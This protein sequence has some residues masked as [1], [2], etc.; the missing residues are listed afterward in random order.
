VNAPGPGSRTVALP[1]YPPKRAARRRTLHTG[2][3][4]F[5]WAGAAL[6]AAS[7]SY[8]LYTYAFTF[9]ES[10][11]GDV[12]LADA[13]ADVALFT[14]FA[15]HHSLFAREGVRAWVSRTLSPAVERSAYVWAASLMLIGVCASWR[16]I[17]GVAWQLPSA[18]AWLPPVAQLGGIALTLRS[19]AV[20][21]VWDLAGVRQ[22][23]T[24]QE[25]GGS[26]FRIEGPYGWVRHPIYLGWFVIVF[27]VGT[28]TMTRLLFA[29]TSAAYI[30][31]AI[32]FEERSLRRASAGAYDR[33]IQ[34]VPWKLIPR[35]Y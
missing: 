7:L 10:T 33:Y 9:A 15:L 13:A 30:L 34:V 11:V 3:G 16:P 32:P 22:A 27:C 29:V 19:A 14:V 35:L 2:E 1:A 8:F 23:S 5:A 20:I 24:P 18:W 25:V 26:E 4:W 12:S 31:I 21:D 6:F 17:P 28:M